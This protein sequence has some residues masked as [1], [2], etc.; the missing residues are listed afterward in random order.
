VTAAGGAPV[1]DLLAL[2]REVSHDYW[3][4]SSFFK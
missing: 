2:L 3:H 1:D 4:G